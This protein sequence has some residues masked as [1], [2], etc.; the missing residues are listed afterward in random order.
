MRRAH[1]CEERGSRWDKIVLYCEIYQ[2]PSPKIEVYN[3]ST[4]I[5]IFSYIPFTKIPIKEKKWSCYMH[6]CLKQVSG[7]QMTN[8]SLRNRF[9]VSEGNKAGISRLIASSVEENLIKPL[10][11]KTAPRYMCYIPFWA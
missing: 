5:T 1:I 10:D 7:E 6:A 9:G 8:T 3:D 2:L 4:R 11:P